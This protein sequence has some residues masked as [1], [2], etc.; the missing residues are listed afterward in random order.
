VPSVHDALCTIGVARAHANATAG[1]GPYD[2]RR[3]TTRSADLQEPLS[4][5]PERDLAMT[6]RSRQAASHA[7][8]KNHSATTR[9]LTSCFRRRTNRR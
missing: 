9:W 2:Y 6:Y 5:C 4:P 1:I 8:G 7:P 3:C